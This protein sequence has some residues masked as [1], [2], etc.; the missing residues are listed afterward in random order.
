MVV[1]EPFEEALS[2]LRIR[3]CVVLHDAYGEPWAIDVPDQQALQ[4]MLGEGPDVRVM[5]FHLVRRGRFELRSAL[6]ERVEVRTGEVVLCPDGAAHRMQ[7]GT[8]SRCCSLPQILA[9]AHP[10][11]PPGDSAT[12]TELICGA[13]VLDPMPP[14]PLLAALPSVLTLPAIGRDAD[15]LLA[16]AADMLLLELGRRSLATG[17]FT[18][19]RLLEIF[20]AE[21]FRAYRSRAIDSVGWF[22][23][24][25]DPRIG[26]AIAAF[27]ERPGH[28]WSV[29]E[30]AATTA[31][32]ASRFSARFRE[33]VGESVGSYLTRWRMTLACRELS[34]RQRP[35]VQVADDLG[36]G[37]VAAFTRAFR[38][39]IGTTPA[40]W[41]AA[42]RGAD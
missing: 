32:S 29:A 37:S 4:A 27:H 6:G 38:A 19:A 28:A 9:G 31:L 16:G 24:L 42:R 21:V 34:D 5:P 2:D 33:S 26:R 39:V 13:F 40:R 23:G 14:N 12:E 15:P 25:E 11:P 3:G 36:Y 22:R 41:R 18:A 17:S 35:I 7:R 10:G 20:C 30:L 1:M 8:G